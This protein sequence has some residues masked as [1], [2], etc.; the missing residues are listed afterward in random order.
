MTTVDFYIL[1]GNTVIQRYIFACRLVEKAYKLGHRVY[2]H[3]DSREQVKEIDEQLWSFRKTSFVPHTTETEDQHSQIVIGCGDVNHLQDGLLVNLSNDVP[4]IFS[5]FDRVSE[6]VVQDP[7]ITASTRESY[8]FY[9]DRGYQL[10]SHD[11]R[12]KH[13]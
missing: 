7:V 10:V 1:P 2:I 8:R 3:A 5:R 13:G 11:M 6:I 12:K 4:D 9:R